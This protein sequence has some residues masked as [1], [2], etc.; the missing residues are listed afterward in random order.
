MEFS[1]DLWPSKSQVGFNAGDGVVYH[2]V[3]SSFTP[4]VI[5]IDETSNVGTTGRWAFQ[6]NEATIDGL[7]TKSKFYVFNNE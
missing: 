4:D 1:V 7:D 6:T 3:S 5:N 2:T